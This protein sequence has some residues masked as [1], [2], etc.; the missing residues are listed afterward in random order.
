MCLKLI[1]IFV[2]G[3][4]LHD[5]LRNNDRNKKIYKIKEVYLGMNR[6][7]VLYAEIVIK[8]IVAVA[9]YALAA[10]F[11]A[12]V[13]ADETAPASTAEGK[14]TQAPSPLPAAA[15]PAGLLMSAL[16]EAGMA[17]PLNKAGINIYGYVEGGSMYDATSPGIHAGPTFIGFNSFK[18]T[19][20]SS[21]RSI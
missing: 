1:S 15:P 16:G 3:T 12:N 2:S 19:A 6:F 13:N 4:V 20:P 8:F 9:C 10:T 18:S 7:K 11:T 17:E 14:Q 21:T 5:H